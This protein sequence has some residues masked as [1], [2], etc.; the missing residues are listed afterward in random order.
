VRHPRY[1]ELSQLLKPRHLWGHVHLWGRHQKVLQRPEWFREFQQ[2]PFS[3]PVPSVAPPT[4]DNLCPLRLIHHTFCPGSTKHRGRSTT[5]LRTWSC[6]FS[7]S[8]K[9]TGK[10]V[11]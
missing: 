7:N 6:Y 5:M 4:E 2:L 11:Q 9:G 8:A 1:L 3:N 10:H